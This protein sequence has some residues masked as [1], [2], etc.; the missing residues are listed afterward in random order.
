ML[1]TVATCNFQVASKR[2]KDPEWMKKKAKPKKTEKNNESD[3]EAEPH[4]D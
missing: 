1:N 2:L 4:Q 3:N